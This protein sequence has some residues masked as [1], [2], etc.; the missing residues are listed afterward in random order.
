MALCLQCSGKQP[1]HARATGLASWLRRLRRENALPPN[2]PRAADVRG[3]RPPRNPTVR[4]EVAVGGPDRLVLYWAAQ[5]RTLGAPAR[6]AASAYARYSNGGVAAVR[7]G[8]LSMDLRAPQPYR[9]GGRLWP[10]HAHYVNMLKRTGRAPEWDASAVYAV[11][12]Y[13]GHHGDAYRMTCLLM[14]PG[15]SPTCC[16]LSPRQVLRHFRAGD[17]FV[18]SALD[19]AEGMILKGEARSL[20]I[21]R[22]T[23]LAEVRRRAAAIGDSPYVVYCR[24]PRCAAAEALIAKLVAVGHMN[25][26]AMP[27]GVEGWSNEV[28]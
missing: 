10:P 23:P 5:P 3:P 8:M 27:A 15:T 17:L 19:G 21:P 25:A 16:F 1:Y 24:D 13:P 12:A 22:A 28:G 7:D 4:I 6:D 18:V 26:Y 9:E 2:A 14:S 11:A 20:Q